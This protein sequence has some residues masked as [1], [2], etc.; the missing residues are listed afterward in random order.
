M[1]G[2]GAEARAGAGAMNFARNASSTALT[3]VART[4]FG[5]GL[6][7]LL[8]RWLSE[9]DR[10][11]YAVVAT[12]AMFGDQVSQLGMRYAV[13]YRMSLPGASRARA[14]GAAFAWTLVTFALLAGL[15]LV[16]RDPLR[17]RFLLGA[18]PV[19]LWLALAL[20]AADLFTG[21]VDAVARGIDRFDL[22]NADQISIAA[23]TLLA[24][25]LALVVFEW[26]LLG[27][28]AAT[29]VARG[30]VLLLFS[31]L[32]LRRSGIDLTPDAHELGESL[33]F[34]VRGHPQTLLAWLHQRVDVML[35]AL[36]AVDPAQIAVYAVAVNVIDRLRVVPDSV[37]SALLPKLATL[38]P[39][40]MGTYAARIT[41][42]LIFW[43][44]LSGLALGLL[45]PFLVPLLFGRPYAASVLPLYVLLPATVMLSVRGMVGSYF[46]AAGR[47]GFNAWVQAGSVA[48]NVAANLWAIPRHG[49]VGAAFAS[50]LSYSVEAIATV[51]V[52]RRVTGCGLGEIVL[53]RRADLRPYLGRMRR[54]RERLGGA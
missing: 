49:I 25:W 2:D 4:F 24:T 32:T 43:V 31:A 26:G 52:F 33:S 19:F 36:F 35:M 50:L 41:R 23:V 21:L 54:L 42:H 9:A 28:L 1:P 48:V 11:I 38:G 13:I 14:V 30:A 18:E 34:G 40:E 20:A 53:A 12:A 3:Q 17:A 8:A 37:S 22:R 39:A 6:A 47:P 15:A 27:T 45:A 10:G 51:L 46:I 29:A 7:I 44:C 16:F 5:L